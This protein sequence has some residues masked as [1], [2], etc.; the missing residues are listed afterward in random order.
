MFISPRFNMW[1]CCLLALCFLRTIQAGWCLKLPEAL[2]VVYPHLIESRNEAGQKVIKVTNNITLNLEKSSVV[3][4]QFLL[5]TYQGDIMEHNY[6]DGELLEE[7]LYHDLNLFASVTVSES[8][9]LTVEGIIGQKY[10]IKPL[11]PQERTTQGN[12]P[13]MMYALTED[14]FQRDTFRRP[15]SSF[16][17][18]RHNVN[19][20]PPDKIILELII[21]VDS[22]FRQQFKSKLELL[23][24]LMITVNSVNIKY[25]TVSDPEVEIKFCALEVINHK[26]ESNFFVRKTWLRIE[27][28][29]TLLKLERY[30]RFNYQKYS[31]YDALYLVTGLD[32][33]SDGIKGW[34]SGQL[35]IAYIGGVCS[36]EKVGIGEDKKDTYEGVRIMAH[37][38][39]HILGCPHDSQQYYRFSSKQCPWY[40]G[41][42][43]THLKNSSNAMKFSTCCNEAITHLVRTTNLNCLKLENAIRNISQKYDTDKLPG[44]VLSRDEVC[45]QSFPEIDDIRYATASLFVYYEI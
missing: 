30:V 17:S 24:Y 29:A 6:L 31:S 8:A 9:G 40:G 3:G 1:S 45:Q 44:E 10:G 5:R 18:S 11:L 7:N 43:M 41:Y 36:T 39:G 16:V 15:V 20:R 4:K 34:E 38:L 26:V 25:L 33:G 22:A 28:F 32:M 35:G 14:K 21:V 23:V 27:G 12:I 13:H 19:Q 42:M 2:D 37:E